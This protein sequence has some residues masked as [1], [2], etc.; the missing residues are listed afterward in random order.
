MPRSMISTSGQRLDSVRIFCDFDGTISTRDI[1]YDLFDRYGEQEPW[2]PDL[3]SGRIG[4][5][6]YWRGVVRT[7]REPLTPELLDSYLRSIP[8]D[9]GFLDLLDLVRRE[10]IP[11]TVLSDGL[12]IYVHRYLELHGLTGLHVVCNEAWTND[13]SELEVRFPY[14]VDGCDCP[15]AVCKRNVLLTASGPDDRIIYIGDGLSDFCPTECADVIFAKGNLAAH[16]NRNGLPHHSWKEMAEVVAALEKLL[17]K[18]RLRPRYQAALA[19][20]RAW[21]SG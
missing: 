21:E 10:G 5:R 13:A 4:I 19:R 8:I 14:A 2:E 18:R 15:S 9:P 11:F 20:K 3:V 17:A 12:S 1:G 16:C 7:L 6:D